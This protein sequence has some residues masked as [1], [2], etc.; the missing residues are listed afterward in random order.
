MKEDKIYFTALTGLR[1]I[2]AYM[3]FLMHYNP[4]SEIRD[5]FFFNFFSQFYT[6]VS[7]FFVLSGFLITYRY[8]IDANL[9]FLWFK[10]YIKNRIARIYPLYFILTLVTFIFTIYGNTDNG[11][12]FLEVLK[13][14]FILFLLNITL[15]RGFFEDYLFSMVGQG[16]SLTVEETF[17][18]LT[19]FIWHLRGKVNLFIVLVFLLFLGY[20]LVIF[21][22]MFP[23]NGFFESDVFMLKFTFF[24]R[25][26]QFAMGIILGYYALSKKEELI[27]NMTYIGLLICLIS[28]LILSFI[29]KNSNIY[30]AIFVD[31]V[32]LSLGVAFLIYG[33]I[34]EETILSKLLSNRLLQLLGKSSYAFYLIHVGFIPD[35]L[36]QM[37]I[38]NVF[39][40]FVLLN[41]FSILLYKLVETPMRLI[42]LRIK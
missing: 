16:W 3:V 42:I 19:P 11:F 4:F 12:S 32:V 21:G 37:N 35:L 25:A 39:L 9:T 40:Q 30:L 27:K 6:G 31:N 34:K 8:F 13:H 1:A 18:L 33:L 36:L 20:I 7:V 26:F 10:R 28:I 22:D 5:G 15:L 14:E 24:G 29:W 38:T 17:Y 2:A 41:V 23:L